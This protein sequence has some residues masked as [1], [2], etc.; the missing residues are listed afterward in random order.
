MSGILRAE[1]SA[2]AVR[3][4][5]DLLR[6]AIGPRVA[7]CA[8]VKA[9]AYGHGLELLAPCL[10]PLV[11]GFAVTLPP[12][13]LKLRRLGWSGPIL[14]F[15]R[16]AGFAHPGA[17]ADLL[18]EVARAEITVTIAGEEDLPLLESVA[19]RVGRPIE[20]HLKVDTGMTRSGILAASAP[21]FVARVRQAAGIRLTGI[22]TQIASADAADQTSAEEQLDTF[23][24]V[25]A[26]VGDVDGL[27][28]HAAN[29][30]ATLVLPRSHHAMV[31]PGLALYGSYPSPAMGR[32]LPLRP[33]LRL[34]A[35]LLEVKDV[36]AGSRS[37]YGLTHTFERDSRIG[38]VA[39]GYA[40]GYPRV[41][42]GRSTMGVR[43]QDVPV[44]GRVSMDQ[45]VVDLT[46]VSA[47]R[48]GDEVEVISPDPASAH[49]LENLARLAETVPYEIVCG[50]GPRVVRRL[51]ED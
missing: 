26:A 33:I 28:V 44:C 3:H 10:A 43:G 7:L 22:Y 20:A 46:D 4:N 48:V 27:V 6:R 42:G 35:Q 40:D 24:R 30:A 23:Q 12:T 47:A 36:P 38:L 8:V 14:V 18:E 31:R 51:I 29:S 49:S 45:V 41:L 2:A 1:I 25:L 9:N 34:T 11:D 15:F 19:A 16:A 5:I 32:P 50:L 13:A 17:V 21:R 37:G 39:V